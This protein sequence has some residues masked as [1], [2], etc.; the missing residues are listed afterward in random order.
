VLVIAHRLS[1]LRSADRIITIEC[2]RVIEDGSH[3]DLI[4]TGG[5][6]ATLYRLQ[7]GLHDD[8]PAASV[9]RPGDAGRPPPRFGRPLVWPVPVY[10]ENQRAATAPGHRLEH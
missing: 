9:I 7:A 10:A 8:A 3:H 2:G 6:Y 1:A 4:R 5:R